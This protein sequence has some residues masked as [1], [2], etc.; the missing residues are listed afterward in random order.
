[1]NLKSLIVLISAMFF[2]TQMRAQD[3]NKT[4]NTW[5]DVSI[6]QIYNFDGAKRPLI[7]FNRE[8]GKYFVEARVNFDWSNSAGV[9]IGKTFSKSDKFWI[10]PK[11]GFIFSFDKSGYNGLSPEVNFGG[12]IGKFKYF[13]MNQ[14]AIDLDD[15]PNFLYQYT[16][17][18]YVVGK[19]TLKYSGQFY[20]ELVDGSELWIDQ[21]PQ[22]VIPFGKKFVFKPWYTWDPTH[23]VQKLIVGIGMSY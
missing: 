11:V 1:M 13:T 8:E 15:D 4:Y 5:T 2:A 3:T 6:F 12:K 23:D 21:G 20:Y 7:W 14:F 22:I 16:E 9:L 17:V 19:I 10:T 18:G